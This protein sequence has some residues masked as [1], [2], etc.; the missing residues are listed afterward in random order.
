VIETLKQRWRATAERIDALGLRERAL[1]FVTTLAVLYV[2][3]TQLVFA[4]LQ[5]ERERLQKQIKSQRDQIQIYEAQ[6][7]HAAGG[8]PD[9]SSPAG[10]RLVMLRQQLKGLDDTLAQTTTGLVSPK[11]MARLVEQVL[12]RNRRLTVV[13]VESLPAT[14]LV[15][16]AAGATA[17]QAGVYKHG[18]RI[19]LRG[20]YLD[21]LAYLKALEGLSWRVFWGQAS[22]QSD[23]QSASRFTLQIYTLSTH[24]SWIGI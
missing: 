20:N 7:M 6:V 23:G 11:E 17:G 24:E 16:V 1:V 18:M 15:D 8:A 10:S 5:A 9:A 22:L 19:E 14:P 13:K 3:A 4:P 21:I 12:S 2:A